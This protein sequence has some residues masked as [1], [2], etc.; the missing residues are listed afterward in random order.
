MIK[1]DIENFDKKKYHIEYKKLTKAAGEKIIDRHS[2][3][4]TVKKIG[5]INS[6][7]FDIGIYEK[8]K[9]IDSYNNFQRKI[10]ETLLNILFLRVDSKFNLY[11]VL[12]KELIC[13]KIAILKE[14]SENIDFLDM[15]FSFLEIEKVLEKDEL[16]NFVIKS[17]KFYDCFFSEI[18]NS[19]YKN[20]RDMLKGTK[21]ISDLIPGI[22]IPLDLQVEETGLKKYLIK[23]ELDT[24]KLSELNLCEQFQEKTSMNVNK[25]EILYKNEIELDELNIIKNMKKKFILKADEIFLHGREIEMWEEV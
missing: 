1:A 3:S 19:F 6:E 11:E 15:D 4:C 12:N 13:K 8:N 14:M 10:E 5:K 9:K 16:L 23:G 17:Y 22:V 18:Y 20:M 24:I 21:Y 2:S 7:L 25:I